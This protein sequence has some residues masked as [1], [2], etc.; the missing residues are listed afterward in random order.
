MTVTVVRMSPDL[1]LAKSYISVLRSDDREEVME[2]LEVHKKEIRRHLGLRIGKQVRIIPELAFFLDD[3]AEYASHMER[4]IG[5]LHI[6]PAPLEE[7]E[8]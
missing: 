2:T 1:G 3:T 4:L 7:E 5:G 6:P 8:E